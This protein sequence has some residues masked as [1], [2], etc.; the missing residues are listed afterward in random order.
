M[1][2]FYKSAALC[3]LAITTVFFFGCSESRETNVGALEN[4]S[5]S[6]IESAF[7]S[8]NG[9]DEL[10][11]SYVNSSKGLTSLL[12][13]SDIPLPETLTSSDN[14]L[15][16]GLMLYDGEKYVP[17]F[18]CD[19]FDEN[20][21]SLFFTHGMGYNGSWYNSKGYFDAGYN[22]FA[23]FWGAFAGE[24]NMNA[25][26]VCDKV[27]FYDGSHRFR[28]ERGGTW[29]DGSSIN[30]S[31][32]EIYAASYCDFLLAHPD[33][34][35]KEITVAGHSYGGMM[36]FGLL[37]YL[38]AAF[39][40]GVLDARLL[41]DRAIMCDPFLMNGNSSRH[42]R[43]LS[44]MQNPDF[45]GVA[46]L[47]YEGVLAAK[48]LGISVSLVRTSQFIAMPTVLA[49]RDL[50]IGNAMLDKLN[51]SLLYV[52]APATNMLNLSDA[53]NYG[54]YW[55]SYVTEEKF[56]S[57][58]PTEY[59]YSP[60][61]PYHADYARMGE[62]YSLNF[63]KTPYNLKDDE[64]TLDYKGKTKIYG[65]VFE[66]ENGNGELDERLS[67][68]IVGAT[69]EIKNSSQDVVFTATTSLSGYFEYFALPDVYT[70]SVT[71]PSGYSFDKILTLTA[72]EG[73]YFLPALIPTEK[74][75]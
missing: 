54:I 48:S 74:T 4:L 65:F 40:S 26:V 45:G 72:D 71:L 60:L 58:N 41:P 11:A 73:D 18:T 15:P 42:V 47:A 39:R 46:Y 21:K 28:T 36:T 29:N 38:T 44:D 23:F 27:W 8:Y 75:K 10:H 67:K 50:E 17:A 35:S 20:K 3:L 14:S 37:S 9:E 13:L 66:D 6:A 2:T 34:T 53:H 30:H 43:W 32:V 51:S 56:D 49:Y 31:L 1:K 63:N 61:N 70:L 52:D 24:D 69:V 12:S 64:I 19:A 68:H 62:T 55:P 16:F 7:S 33:Y 25:A 22:V 59:A 57:S 5:L